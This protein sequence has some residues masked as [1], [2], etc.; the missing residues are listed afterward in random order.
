M[1]EETKQ[2]KKQKRR[3][4]KNESENEQNEE[5]Q[6]KKR[7]TSKDEEEEKE[8]IILD[9]RLIAMAANML[10]DVHRGPVNC[11]HVPVD[12]PPLSDRDRKE[13][14][15]AANA[16]FWE[17]PP[18]AKEERGKSKRVLQSTA[19]RPAR[20]MN[21]T[22][23]IEAAIHELFRRRRQYQPDDCAPLHRAHAK[24][25]WKQSLRL[26]RTYIQTT[27]PSSAR[28]CETPMETKSSSSLCCRPGWPGA[29]KTKVLQSTKS[30][31]RTPLSNS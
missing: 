9:C 22:K 20:R 14:R 17:L 6:Q 25:L 29:R 24:H 21:S 7:K 18:A 2:E 3:T 13:L 27:L 31:K 26:H 15:I 12:L 5:E 4:P 23:D 28:T 16:M 10:S 11:L 1:K 19:T 30:H 8:E